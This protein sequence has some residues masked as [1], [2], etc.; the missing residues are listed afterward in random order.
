MFVFYPAL[1]LY[2]YPFLILILSAILVRHNGNNNDFSFH[3]GPL[4]KFPHVKK[5][6][7]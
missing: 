2:Y 6:L 3:N 1:K 7:H 5:A 4:N